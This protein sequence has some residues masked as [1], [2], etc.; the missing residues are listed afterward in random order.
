MSSALIHGAG[1][2]GG[3]GG[4]ITTFFHL[5]FGAG[6]GLTVVLERALDAWDGTGLWMVAGPEMSA[7][8]SPTRCRH[9]S[10]SLETNENSTRNDIDH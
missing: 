10:S 3:G 5:L 8:A 2:G 1:W 4:L 6:N 9:L 7:T